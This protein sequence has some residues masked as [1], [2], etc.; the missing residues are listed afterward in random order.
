ME[1]EPGLQGQR[2]MLRKGSHSYSIGRLTDC[3]FP[4]LWSRLILHFW[5]LE[6][7]RDTKW[8]AFT[9][10]DAEPNPIEYLQRAYERTVA[11][12]SKPN[13]WLGTT[14]ACAAILASL[15]VKKDSLT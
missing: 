14:T 15:P 13:E 2:G 6:A 10:G 1:L 9:E 11:A 5:S 8:S 4:S 12:T 3:M 7:E